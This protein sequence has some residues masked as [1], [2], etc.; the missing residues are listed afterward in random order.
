MPASI[1]VENYLF[2]RIPVLFNA[3]RTLYIDWKRKLGGL[4]E[5]DPACIAI[6]GSAATGV[7]LSPTK[8]LK[9]FDAASDV[10]VAVISQHHFNVAWRY[11]R[12]NGSRRLRVDAR[13]RNSWNDH[14]KRYIYWGTIATDR[15]LGVLPFGKEWLAATIAMSLEPSSLGRTI[16][17]RIYTDY[18]A[19]RAY[20]VH[21]VSALQS[22]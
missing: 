7:S 13:T 14:V 19:L 4:I 1:F 2:D 12:M 3:D 21:G 9:E 6:V 11:L 10:D 20:Q 15:L 22:P 16:N 8:N 18:D 17:L 5:V